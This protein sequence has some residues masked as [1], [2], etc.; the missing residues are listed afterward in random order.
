MFR[1]TFNNSNG[2]SN[3]SNICCFSCST[4]NCPKD[5]SSF[6]FLTTT[7]ENHKN[8]SEWALSNHILFPQITPFK[9]WKTLKANDALLLHRQ[10][11]RHFEIS[12]RQH[13][14]ERGK[15]KQVVATNIR[16]FPQKCCTKNNNFSV[17]HCIKLWWNIKFSSV[18]RF[19]DAATGTQIRV[20]PDPPSPR[21]SWEKCRAVPN[22]QLPHVLCGACAYR[23][24][25]HSPRQ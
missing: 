18:F 1:A 8:R 13:S 25:L 11:Q 20:T 2:N 9:L 12:Q 6:R 14:V 22:Q 24:A 19:P 21:M 5:K 23:S 16:I 7:I 4:L 17:E 10:C 15:T 3:N